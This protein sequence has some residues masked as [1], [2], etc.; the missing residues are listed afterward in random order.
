L[1]ASNEW[2]EYHLTPQ[3][4]VDGSEK[5][6]FSG[7]KEK[8][9]PA[10]RVLTLR[11]HEYMSSGFSPIDKWCDEQFRHEDKLLVNK[12]LEQFGE[13]PRQFKKSDYPKRR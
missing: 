4:W 7:V 6:D 13:V 8:E 1:S 11:F 10:D 3:G 2:F 12:L 5:I 9:P